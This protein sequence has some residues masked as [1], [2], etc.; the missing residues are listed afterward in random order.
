MMVKKKGPIT[1]TEKTFI[2]LYPID[3][4]MTDAELMTIKVVA[5]LVEQQVAQPLALLVNPF[6]VFIDL[7]LIWF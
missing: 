3:T 6:N 4:P 1:F 5:D 7:S 2:I